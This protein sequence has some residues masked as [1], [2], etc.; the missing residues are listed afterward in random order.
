LARETTQLRAD[1]VAVTKERDEY[2]DKIEATSNM[3]ANIQDTLRAR[4]F[5]EGQLQQRVIYM[6]QALD[7]AKDDLAATRKRN[8]EMR[9]ALTDF[10]QLH[11]E[12]GW[13]TPDEKYHVITTAA[14][15]STQSETKEGAAR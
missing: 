14:A 9:E 11:A 15:L 10:Y 5:V 13:S 3:V 1:L 2:G 6:A 7:K 12:S 8:E 4:G